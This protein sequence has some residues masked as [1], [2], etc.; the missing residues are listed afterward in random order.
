MA[1]RFIGA[2]HAGLDQASDIRVIAS[3]AR[4]RFTPHKVKAAIP[5]VREVEAE[6]IERNRSA[7][8]AHAASLML[9]RTVEL[10]S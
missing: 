7:S 2:E 3:E 5:D 6:I 1:L 4:N 10:P 9:S 8:G